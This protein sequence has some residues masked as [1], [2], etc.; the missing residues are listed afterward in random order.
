MYLDVIKYYNH[1]KSNSN[2]ANK[3][4]YPSFIDVAEDT[5]R[6]VKKL[7]KKESVPTVIYNRVV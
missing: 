2:S 7:Y 4:Y 5:T 3:N 6:E 1:V